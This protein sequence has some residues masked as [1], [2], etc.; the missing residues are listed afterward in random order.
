M[1]YAHRNV[2]EV[3]GHSPLYSPDY[4]FFKNSSKLLNSSYL[5]AAGMSVTSE[6][7]RCYLEAVGFKNRR[8]E[9]SNGTFQY[10]PPARTTSTLAQKTVSG[11]FWLMAQTVGSKLVNTVGQ[12]I[13]AWLLAPEYFGLIGLAY[14]V[15]AFAGLI[16]QAGLR[17]I[18]I[19]RQEHFN[20]W[21][22]PAFWMSLSLGVA[23]AVITLILAPVAAWMYEDRQL[24]PLVSLLAVNVLLSPFEVVPDAKL[25]SELRFRYLAVVKW[26]TAVGTMGL[27]IIFALMGKG[28]YS[29]VLPL[30]IIT[31]VRL[32]MLWSA[33]RPPI[34][35]QF[36][37]K[38]W[39]YLMNDSALLFAAN[40]FII[41]TWQGDYMI[42]G[43]MHDPKTVGIYFFAFNLATQ[44]MQVFT[45]NLIGVLFPALSKLQHNIAHQT[46]A[47]LKAA[48]LLAVIGVPLC[49]LQAALAGPGINLLFNSWWQDMIR[50]LQLLSI[51]MAVRLVASPG[52][53]LIQ[54]QGRFK[55]Y[56]VT[57]AIN[58]VFFLGLVWLG[59]WLGKFV[60]QTHLPAA[61][62]VAGAVMVYFTLIGPVFLWIAIRPGG[63][64]WRDVWRVYFAPMAASLI[65]VGVAV[66]FG[67]MIQSM[68]MSNDRVRQLLRIVAILLWSTVLYIP[69]IRMMAPVAFKELLERLSGIIR[70]KTGRG[71]VPTPVA[72]TANV[73]AP[74]PAAAGVTAQHN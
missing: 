53:A 38:R 25:T 39:K 54:A 31:L 71:F 56:L 3:G 37:F 30:P 15:T 34:R 46:R 52:G 17:E 68:P 60:P 42:L 66:G 70:S 22:N 47:F 69:L 8:Q 19:H 5:A 41:L 20:R 72:A 63:G 10:S 32:V 40:F 11:F 4:D 16:Q 2:A 21:A 73:T 35:W 28:A 29:F 27:S 1:G 62:Y 55:T 59:A 49:L 57:N 33:A 36:H 12:V 14:T 24:I 13:L 44:T 61:R 45:Q 64:K 74:T 6:S 26:I 43:I 18:L 65:A 50:V 23:G 58:A 51:G 9:L 67:R 7:A 48:E